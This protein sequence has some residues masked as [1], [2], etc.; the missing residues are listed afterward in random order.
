MIKY[1]RLTNKNILLELTMS[2]EIRKKEFKTNKAMINIIQKISFLWR[3]LNF[4]DLIIALIILMILGFFIYNRLQRQIT[5]INVRISVE[6]SDWWYKG[7]E[8]SYWYASNLKVGDVIKDSAGKIVAEVSK[9]DNYDGGEYYRDIYVDLKLRVDF[10]KKKKQYL[11]EFKPLVVGSSLLLNFA[12]FQLRGLVIGLE[13]QH[14]QYL[15]KTIKVSGKHAER[16]K[17]ANSLL[18]TKEVAEKVQPGAQAFA[19][20]GE[21]VAEVLEVKK[22]PAT[23]HEYSD[24]RGRME[25]VQN[26]DF[27]DLEMLVKVKALQALGIYYYVNNTALKVGNF[28]W[29]Q[30]PEFALEDMKIIEIMD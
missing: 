14:P 23:Y 8:P 16:I 9:V 3:K 17:R 19:G 4:F 22:K 5:W 15:Y 10:D 13:N 18:I 12:Q 24:I 7:S 20:N 6:N 28:I 27:Y 30:F 2:K 25:L 21:L 1:T 26:P 29:L 11:Y